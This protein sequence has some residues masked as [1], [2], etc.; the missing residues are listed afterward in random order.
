[1]YTTHFTIHIVYMASM[2]YGMNACSSNRTVW[3]GTS[4]GEKYLSS[5]P[6][7]LQPYL[8]LQLPAQLEP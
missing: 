5:E 1:M 2:V 8:E 4:E 3:L 7:K 6:L